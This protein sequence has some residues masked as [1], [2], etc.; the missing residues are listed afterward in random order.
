MRSCWEY[1]KDGLL[2]GF[3]IPSPIFSSSH[4]N[5]NEKG[6]CYGNQRSSQEVEIFG[7][8][9]ISDFFFLKRN[10][11]I[12]KYQNTKDVSQSFL[13]MRY[14]ISFT[15]YFEDPTGLINTTRDDYTFVSIGH[16]HSPVA[17]KV[18]IGLIF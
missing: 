6:S 2:L 7:N 11:L 10:L 3:A 5:F 12:D 17:S 9:H 18:F 8:S 4:F 1:S 14:P 16:Y 13:L 15:M